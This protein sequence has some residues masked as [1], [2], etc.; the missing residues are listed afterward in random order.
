MEVL[1]VWAPPDLVGELRRDTSDQLSFQYSEDWLKNPKNFAL[2]FS[3]KLAK[4]AVY[5]KEAE[6]YFAN[7]LP[8]GNARE[9]LCRKLGISVAND[10]ELLKRIGRD[11]AG[12]LVL[13]D[14][15]QLIDEPASLKE[16]S[17]DDLE[18]WLKQGSSGLLDLQVSGELRLSLAGAQD[19][20]LL[21]FKDNKFYQPLGAHPTTHI[22][23][24]APQRFKYLPEN[25]FF[26]ARLAANIGL[27]VATSRLVKIGGVNSLLVTRYDRY[28]TEA[29]WARLHQED[30]CQ[31]L[32]VSGKMKYQAEGGP[33]FLD[34]IR[35][36][37]DR[38]ANVVDDVDSLLRWHIFNVLI[39]NCD[40]HAKNI[41]LLRNLTGQWRL[42]PFYDLVSTK[43]YSQISSK[44]AMSVSGQYD[45]GGAHSKHWLLLFKECQVSPAVYSKILIKM[46]KSLPEII[47]QTKSDFVSEYGEST[48]IPKLE[49]IYHSQI[50]RILIGFEGK[51]F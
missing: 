50:R 9:T 18:R 29:G 15:N 41:S 14:A 22:L 7:L 39:G 2:S 34:C 5:K 26:Q 23:K 21:V 45:S 47:A 40:A 35:I 3:L 25:E 28:Q 12:A 46:A 20:L 24:P 16:I 17:L 38:S 1:Y 13:T 43:T 10:F 19:K 37:N 4:G 11:C 36:I 48:I 49:K 44:L 31:A 30:F 51:G 32:G 27:P 6:F 42:A 33:S 8:E